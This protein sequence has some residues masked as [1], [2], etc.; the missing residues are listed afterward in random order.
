MRKDLSDRGLCEEPEL[1]AR[2]PSTKIPLGDIGVCG[3]D[4]APLALASSV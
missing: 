4:Q 2:G 1:L 3:A